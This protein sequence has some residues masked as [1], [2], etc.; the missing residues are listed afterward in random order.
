MAS[1][2]DASMFVLFVQ[3][4]HVIS[5]IAVSRGWDVRP[6]LAELK[7]YNQSSDPLLFRNYPDFSSNTTGDGANLLRRL[8]Q[9]PNLIKANG[10]GIIMNAKHPNNVPAHCTPRFVKSWREKSGKP[11]PTA[12]RRMVLAAKTDAALWTLASLA[13]DSHSHATGMH[14]Q[15]KVRINQ[16]VKAL[17][18][19]D[20]D[21]ESGEYPRSRGSHPVD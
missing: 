12:D 6:P 5:L 10:I 9:G 4:T 18:E 3:L 21:S 8:N 11:A 15:L 19:D 17:Q 7:S 14:S 2:T 20:V 1:A 13:H 16:I